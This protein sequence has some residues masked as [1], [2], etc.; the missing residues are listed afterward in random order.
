MLPHLPYGLMAKGIRT[1]FEARRLTIASSPVW[2][3]PESSSVPLPER[4]SFIRS[5][6]TKCISAATAG[7][8]RDAR[9]VERERCPLD[10]EIVTSNPISVYSQSGASAM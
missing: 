2:N 5:A 6:E 10:A 1:L 7:E 4:V 8:E 9:R 3:A